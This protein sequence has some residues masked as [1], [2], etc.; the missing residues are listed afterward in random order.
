MRD[1]ALVGFALARRMPFLV[2]LASPSV[3]LF[4]LMSLITIVDYD[5]R[6][7]PP[8]ELFLVPIAGAGL[9][10]LLSRR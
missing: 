4:T 10:W 6:Y 8:A 9:S 7:Q 1:S 2:T 3:I 5:Q